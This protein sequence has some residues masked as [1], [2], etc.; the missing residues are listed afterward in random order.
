[1]VVAEALANGVPVIASK[2]MPWSKLE[3]EGCGLWLEND[4]QILASG[5]QQ[6]SKMPL[7]EVGQRGREW[8]RRDFS[9]EFVA[10]EMLKLCNKIALA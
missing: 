8:M 4:P 7:R 5:I 6:M 2:G 9:W 3:F 1:M 10:K